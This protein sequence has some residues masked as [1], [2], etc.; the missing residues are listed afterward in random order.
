MYNIPIIYGFYYFLYL[1]F[2]L[3]R[4]CKAVCLP[5]LFSDLLTPVA[6]K[7]HEDLCGRVI[8]AFVCD[9]WL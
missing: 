1:C 3:T 4:Q 2:F 6:E 8:Y 5:C 9:A 7:G